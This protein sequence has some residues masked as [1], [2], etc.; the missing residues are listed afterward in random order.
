MTWLNGGEARLRFRRDHVGK[1]MREA[2]FSLRSTVE[3][4]VELTPDK[5]GRGTVKLEAADIDA[6]IAKLSHYRSTMAP[7]VPRQLTNSTDVAG[8]R[9]PIWILHVPPGSTDRLLLVRHPGLGWMMFRLP[10][11]EATK[12]GHALLP[13]RPQPT[14]DER[15]LGSHLN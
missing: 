10:A 2:K 1:I 4:A 12:L 3:L 7:E 6:L 15:P 9:D 8:V 13:N 14:A 5:A 11:A